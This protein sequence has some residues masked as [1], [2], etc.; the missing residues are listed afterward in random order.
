MDSWRLA[1]LHAAKEHDARS[2]LFSQPEPQMQ[3]VCTCNLLSL[4]AGQQTE[5]RLR[6]APIGDQKGVGAWLGP[7]ACRPSE[8]HGALR[9]KAS[10][11][12]DDGATFRGQ[13]KDL[14]PPR[15][16]SITAHHICSTSD[17]VLCVTYSQSR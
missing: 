7:L 9:G 3:G 4:K 11:D 1:D 17:K 15:S 14:L 12:D 8:T 5:C 2:F 10:G 6:R 16:R 13:H